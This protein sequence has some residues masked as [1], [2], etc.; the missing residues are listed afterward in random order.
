MLV[1][2][3]T[4]DDLCPVEDV[5]EVVDTLSGWDVEVEYWREEGEGH[6]TMLFSEFDEMAA[7]L[8]EHQRELRPEHVHKA[9]FEARD[10][11]AYW[12]VVEPADDL[13]EDYGA[14][15]LEP[16]A[17]V[18]ATWADGVVSLQTEGVSVVGLRWVEGPPGPGS[19]ALGDTVEV[20]DDGVSLGDFTLE[21][22]PALVVETWCQTGDLTRDWAGEVWVEL[23]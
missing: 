18:D 8:A 15:G 22:D 17:L 2:H 16:R 5:D 13:S 11:D 23:P 10:L 19:G 20:V 7:W 12:L 14:Y 1:V 21:E 6:G 4:E 3:G 9:V